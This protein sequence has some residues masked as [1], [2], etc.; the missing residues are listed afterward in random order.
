VFSY[1]GV[2]LV[3]V[4]A[5]EAAN[6]AD[7]RW[8]TKHIAYVILVIYGMT[9]GGISANVEWFDKNL[10]QSYSQNLVS[11]GNM[12]VSFLGHSPITNETRAEGTNFAPV[13]AALEAGASYKAIAGFLLGCLV[14]S[15]L[16]CANGNLYVAS[17]TLYGITRDLDLNSNNSFESF[18]AHLNVVT[19]T[20]RVPLWSVISSIVLVASWLPFVKLGL[21]QQDVS[22]A[23]PFNLQHTNDSSYFKSCHLLV[24]SACCL[25]GLPSAS[26]SSDITGG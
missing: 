24:V 18:F 2:E 5:F 9:V 4:T 11:A 21:N 26:H 16:S 3:T 10:P 8:T 15:A 13:I 25:S 17:R 12:D 22:F 20:W 7:L 6:P 14:Y 1:I 19:P 23:L